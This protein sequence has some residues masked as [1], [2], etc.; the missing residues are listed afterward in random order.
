MTEN[1]YSKEVL[2]ISIRIA[3]EKE[4]ERERERE[5]DVRDGEL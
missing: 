1:R 3:T 5:R 4:G 2:D